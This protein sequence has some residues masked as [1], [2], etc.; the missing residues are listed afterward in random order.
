MLFIEKYKRELAI[1]YSVKALAKV[2]ARKTA[3]YK[4]MHNNYMGGRWVGYENEVKT[5]FV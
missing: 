4:N 5:I 1:R 2:R 3:N